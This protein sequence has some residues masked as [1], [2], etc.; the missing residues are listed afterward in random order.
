[1]TTRPIFQMSK[2]RLREAEGLEGHSASAGAGV[3][4]GSCHLVW[5]TEAP[6]VPDVEGAASPVLEVKRPHV[7]ETG[8]SG[9]PAVPGAQAVWLSIC[10]VGGGDLLCPSHFGGRKVADGWGQYC[11]HM[12]SMQTSDPQPEPTSVFHG[13]L[14]V[15]GHLT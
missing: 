14:C 10:Q 7:P 12:P 15:L 3:L 4:T 5:E 13:V 8:F 11:S 6:Q 1:M 9:A 2:W